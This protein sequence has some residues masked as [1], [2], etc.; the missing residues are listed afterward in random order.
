MARTTRK[1]T[2]LDLAVLLVNIHKGAEDKGVGFEDAE[3][4]LL[5]LTKKLEGLRGIPLKSTLLEGALWS[6]NLLDERGK[7]WHPQGKSFEDYVKTLTRRG[8]M[9]DRRYNYFKEKR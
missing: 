3:N 7:F 9:F 1:I 2:L 6:C 5:T 4:T 8:E